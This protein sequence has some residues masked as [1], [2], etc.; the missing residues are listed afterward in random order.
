MPKSGCQRMSIV[1][2]HH[3]YTICLSNKKIYVA[4][5]AIRNSNNQQSS[6][7]SQSVVTAAATTSAAP[8]AS[9]AVTQ[10][11]NKSPNVDQMTKDHVVHA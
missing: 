5:R 2:E 10:P 4:K 3:S 9:G 11:E 6:P 1:F 8:T 7:T